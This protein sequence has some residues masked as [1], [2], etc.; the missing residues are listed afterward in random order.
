MPGTRRLDAKLGATSAIIWWVGI[1]VLFA[2][3]VVQICTKTSE[4]DCKGG[5]AFALVVSPLWTGLVLSAGI[6]W[7]ISS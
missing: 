1:K 5:N 7:A 3:G 6:C 2:Y 4:E